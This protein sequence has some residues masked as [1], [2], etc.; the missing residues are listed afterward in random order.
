MK[1]KCTEYSSTDQEGI[2]I[3]IITESTM[4]IYGRGKHILLCLI[5]IEDISK[6]CFHSQ[7]SFDE[8]AFVV[9]NCQ[10][11]HSQRNECTSNFG[12]SVMAV[13]RVCKRKNLAADDVYRKPNTE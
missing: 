12:V 7:I 11:E 3:S 13:I 6:M 4:S 5:F 2:L 1:Q 10:Y 8:K 9:N